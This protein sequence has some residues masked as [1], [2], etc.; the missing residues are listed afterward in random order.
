MLE[1]FV[2]FMTDGALKRIPVTQIN[3]MLKLAVLRRSGFSAESLVERCVADIAFVADNLAFAA[4][5]LPVVAS[6]TALNLVMTDVI[7]VRLPVGF[8]FGKEISLVDSLNLRNR[9]ADRVFFRRVNVR[10]IGSIILVE[11]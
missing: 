3:R 9:A 11:G 8:H 1:R 2:R 4:Y 7:S 6:E 10:V 5:V